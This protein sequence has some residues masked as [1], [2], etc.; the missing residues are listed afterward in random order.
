MRSDAPEPLNYREIAGFDSLP[1]EFLRKLIVDQYMSSAFNNCR[2]L[3]FK[4][5]FT[6]Q[7]LQLFVDPTIKPVAIRKAA[8][9]PIH[10]K[11]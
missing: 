10:L 6:E 2:N 9:I 3:N 8:V 1:T 4:M 7:P 11:A 5:M